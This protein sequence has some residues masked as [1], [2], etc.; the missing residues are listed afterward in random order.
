MRN[1]ILLFVLYI[2]FPASLFSLPIDLTESP[3]YI[4]QG[5]SKEWINDLPM[6]NDSSW[7]KKD[8]NKG[9]RPIRIRELGYENLPKFKHFSVKKYQPETFTFVTSFEITEKELK[10]G[11]LGLY[12]AQIGQNWIIYLNGIEIKNQEF[13]EKDG[14]I[15]VERAIRGE[16][17]EIEYNV[18]KIGKN[19]LA[20]KIIGDPTDDRTGFFMGQPYII[21]NYT[22]LKYDTREYIDL[23]L[24]AVYL[25]FGIYHIIL[26]IFRKKE[27]FNF[28]Y[29]VGTLVLSTY[30]ICR[31]QVIYTII[32][33]SLF[34]KNAELMSVFLIL[35]FFT[36]F[37]DLM[38]RNRLTLFIKFYGAFCLILSLMVTIVFRESILRIWQ[39]TVLVPLLYIFIFDIII[40]LFKDAKTRYKSH[41]V[42]FSP[43]K[44]LTSL[45]VS[46]VR[47]I[48]GN[49]LIGFTVILLTSIFDIIMINSPNQ[50]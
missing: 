16:L 8:A 41:A 22:K 20:F 43:I 12:L 46:I 2:L 3:I 33:D 5:F 15:K 30:L 50:T 49:V 7:I 32:D 36:A 27:R 1:K 11:S 23:M 40:P 29:G 13:I 42:R 10:Y 44:I 17:I 28:Y 6:E 21:E 31:S 19:I 48:P 9:N 25:F 34:I 39:A 37:M 47:S 18:L 14:S 38:I 45:I 4:K 35:P 26:F 24:I